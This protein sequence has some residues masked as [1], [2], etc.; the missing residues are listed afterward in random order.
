MDIRNIKVIGTGK[1]LPS[2]VVTAEEIDSKLGL[3]SGWTAK[4]SGVLTRHHVT[5]ETTS[6]MGAIA[7]ERALQD[8]GITKHDIDCILSVSGT[9]EQPIPSNAALF[10]EKLGLQ[11]S[12]IP[13]FDINSTCLS[14]VTGLDTISYLVEAGRY[15]RVLLI[16]SEI[17]SVGINWNHKESAVL[18]GDGAVAVVIEK[19][20]S[21]SSKILSSHMQTFSEGAHLTEIRGGGTKLHARNHNED[22]KE[23]FLFHMD[24]KAVFKMSSKVIHSFVDTLLG[25]ANLSMDDI[26]LVIPHQASGMAMR[27]LRNKL[28]ISEDKFMNIIGNHGN[29]IAS[30]IPMALHEAIQQKKIQR[31][32]K[33]MLFGT[34]AGL[35]LG[36][37][38]LE[39]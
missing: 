28:G 37:I 8:A 2:N 1:Y 31:G 19:D 35:S 20:E 29:T 39:Y 36:G 32:D 17:A 18:F 12:G 3:S 23:E 25:N 7:A 15:K 5:T 9:Y 11:G 22:N 26:D 14:F 38:I 10:Q 6:E 27:I 21:Q 30:S 33:V 4:K 24:G 34:S 13:S 16:S